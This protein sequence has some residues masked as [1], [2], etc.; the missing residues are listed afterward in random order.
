MPFDIRAHTVFLLVI[1]ITCLSESAGRSQTLQDR[2]DAQD[3]A[4][5]ARSAREQGDARRGAVLFHQPYLAC[6]KCHVA[7]ST[8]QT[9]GPDLTRI[10]KETSDVHLVEAI[11]QPSKTIR[12]GFEPLSIS[13]VD[14]ATI[15]GFVMEQR[16]NKLVIRD[17]ARNGLPVD[18]DVDE[19]EDRVVRNV[20]IM[21]A[22]QVNQLASQQQFLDLIHY[23]MEIRDGGL[24]R[25]RRLQPPPALVAARTLP[26]YERRIDH[27]GMIAGFNREGFRRGEAIYDR[28]CANCHG[29]H[30]RP[31]TLP[32]SLPFASGKF[33]NGQDPYTMYQTLT[34]GFG[35]M[36]AQAWMVPQQ[37]Y[38]VGRNKQTAIPC[39]NCGRV[40]HSICVFISNRSKCLRSS[41]S[42]ACDLVPAY[43][44]N[45]GDFCSPRVS[46]FARITAAT[47]TP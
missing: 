17:V 45:T 32:T 4:A 39:R 3:P 22:G 26:E 42:V 36:V 20:S 13:T 7:G 1:S 15:T 43:G 34:R 46:F 21:P 11:L 23:L 28:L 24:D 41:G 25:A 16:D 18:L 9:L 35:M 19:I 29:T 33:K 6:A 31:G 12:K 5:L 44:L 30:D 27:A 40:G 8:N 2:L 10:G 14:G 47:A 37:Q 38:G